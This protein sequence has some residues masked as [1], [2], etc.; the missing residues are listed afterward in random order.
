MR[1]LSLLPIILL[2]ACGSLP[3]DDAGSS[4]NVSV[5]GAV[6]QWN[7][8]GG[9]D[10]VSV[11][12]MPTT[13]TA[14]YSGNMAFAIAPTDGTGGNVTTADLFMGVNFGS[15]DITGTAT[16]FHDTEL[17]NING[18]GIVDGR[19]SGSGMSADITAALTGFDPEEGQSFDALLK[20]NLEGD[21]RTASTDA[22]PD[23]ISGTVSGTMTV[24]D[25]GWT[26]GVSEGKFAVSEQ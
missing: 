19:V 17:G 22:F 21:F 18:T 11:A 2:T 6:N 15:G 23:G 26:S 20:L 5:T 1:Y 3:D 25:E 16:N 13:G 4:G 24:P 14:N 9:M 12:D 7:A 8:V 10:Q